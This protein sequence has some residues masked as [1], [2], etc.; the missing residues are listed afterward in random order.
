[1]KKCLRRAGI[2]LLSGMLLCACTKKEDPGRGS[3]A[4]KDTEEVPTQAYAEPTQAVEA[5]P[6]PTPEPETGGEWSEY[7][8]N[9]E[10]ENNG[11]YIIRVG[12]RVY[13]RTYDQLAVPRTEIGQ[14]F[15]GNDSAEYGSE[16][17]YYDLSDETRGVFAKVNGSGPLYACQDGFLLYDGT[18]YTSLIKPDGSEVKKYLEGQALGVSDDGRC[19]AL[20]LY[21]GGGSDT[22]GLSMAVDGVMSDT[23]MGGD[24]SYAVFAG[25][26]EDTMIATVSDYLDDSHIVAALDTNGVYTSLGEIQSY[27]GDFYPLSP[28]FI[29]FVSSGD[30]IALE[31]GF[32]DGTAYV[33]NAAMIYTGNVK[34]GDSMMPAVTFED[35]ME[36]SLFKDGGNIL[37][38]EHA[39][40]EVGL[41]DGNRGDLIYYTGTEDY[42]TVSPKYVRWPE[43]DYYDVDSWDFLQEGFITGD[44][45][46]AIKAVAYRNPDEDFGWRWA[47]NLFALDYEV[48]DLSRM[49]ES[50]AEFTTLAYIASNSW[51]QGD[52]TLAD[53]EGEWEIDRL[54]MEGSVCYPAENDET[55]IFIVDGKNAKMIW[56]YPGDSVMTEAVWESDN[57]PYYD[58]TYFSV[59]DDPSQT[60]YTVVSY[61]YNAIEVFVSYVYEDGTYGSWYG[62][63]HRK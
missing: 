15:L 8:K 27:E 30:D 55:Y 20:G 40:G 1:M 17:C 22:T 26:A 13:F 9:G 12:D 7:F 34:E 54:T 39:P 6:T 59:P 46:F 37:W 57:G 19:V 50:G 52:F 28:V 29:D 56:D 24:D 63:F 21:P 2:V 53:L 31:Y 51:D 44:K 62:Y 42:S 36:R 5:T 49:R 16:I 47:Y 41:S 10:V 61:K 35:G 58:G 23:M 48:Y 3:Y 11:E 32:Y 43:E 14:Y 60:G 4:D 18:E 33:L 45:L 38:G 25:F